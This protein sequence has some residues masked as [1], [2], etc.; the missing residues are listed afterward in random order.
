VAN[1]AARC[2]V[3]ANAVRKGPRQFGVHVV[4]SKLVDVAECMVFR[5]LIFQ[6]DNAGISSHQFCQ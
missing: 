6:A 5:L 2:L 1:R 3:P 4:R